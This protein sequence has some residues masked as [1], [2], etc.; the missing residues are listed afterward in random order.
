MIP[1]SQ[2]PVGKEGR[3][4]RMEGSG[5]LLYRLIALG[6]V[7]GSGVR[8]VRRA[9]LGDPL[10]IEVD[11]EYRLTLRREEADRILVEDR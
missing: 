8:L 11:G 5:P 9:I 4:V 6:L 7:E 10:E 2:L 3:I 1:L